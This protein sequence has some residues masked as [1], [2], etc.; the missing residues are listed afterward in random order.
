MNAHPFTLAFPHY[1]FIK[2]VPALS[3]DVGQGKQCL[4]LFWLF[5]CAMILPSCIRGRSKP[6]GRLNN[7]ISKGTNLYADGVIS[8]QPY[9]VQ[10]VFTSELEV[11][12]KVCFN[13]KFK[14]RKLPNNSRV[15]VNCRVPFKC[16][17]Q[18]YILVNNR[19]FQINAGSNLFF[20][21]SRR[22]TSS[23]DTAR[24]SSLPFSHIV[25]AFSQS[26]CH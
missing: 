3:G 25:L 15:S 23:T 2:F 22:K 8:L 1:L 26:V 14:N 21:K 5:L 24:F 17:V 18:V 20:K 13:C 19:R 10:S 12:A 6:S 9:F 7:K 11:K 4:L 16:R